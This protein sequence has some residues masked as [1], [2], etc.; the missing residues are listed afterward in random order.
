MRKH[1]STA[2]TEAEKK[3]A[4]ASFCSNPSWSKMARENEM[5]EFTRSF[6]GGRPDLSTLTHSIVRQRFL[7][8]TGRDHLDPEEKQALKQLV[9]EELL[10]MQVDEAGARDEGLD[11][12]R[13]A[14]RLPTHCK[15]PE[16]KRFRLN[17][18]SEPSAATSSPD[19]IS[20]PAKNG[21]AAIVSPKQASKSVESRDGEEQQRDL[22]A[23]TGL[24]K[25]VMK[26]SCKEE[27]ES[28]ARTN[29]VWKEESSEEEDGE[30]DSKGRARKKPGT[31]DRTQRKGD[32]RQ[33]GSSEE[34]GKDRWRKLRPATKRTRKSAKVPSGKT[35]NGEASDSETEVSDI[36]AEGIPKGK[37][38]NCS[39]RKSSK[40]SR[41][42][43][44]SSSSNGSPEFKGGRVRVGWKTTI[45]NKQAPGEISASRKQAMEENNSEEEPTQGTGN[46][47]AKSHQESEKESEEEETLAKKENRE[48]EEGWKARA[49]GNRGEKSA[50]EERSSKQKSRAAR[51]LGNGRER[52]E[53]KE[54][55]AADSGDNSGGDEELLMQRKSRGRTQGKG[56][57]RQSGSSEEDGEDRWR[58]LRPA[59][60]STG[61]SAKV[62]SGKTANG[63]ASD[64]EREVSDSEAGV[65]LKE[66]RKNRS[67][68]K[69]S[70]KCR[71]QSSSSSSNGSP[72]PKG[73]KGHHGE[74]HPAVMR[75]KRYIRACGAH[76]NYK[77]L[78]GSC[79]SH[80]E[81]LCILRAELEALGIKGNP[82]LEKC[83]ALK[84]Q[85]EEAAEVASL[86]ITNI[87]SCSGRPRRR[88]AWNPSEAAT[89]GELYR[90]ALDSEEERRR[91]PRPDWSH[92]RGIISSDGESN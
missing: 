77:K 20:P 92:M 15:E 17:S 21:M 70:K 5:Q 80:K 76:R 11:L 36:E 88:T 82:S 71:T 51:V 4:G 44:S 6:F 53:E 46:T 19:C 33:S 67:Y 72:E 1:L 2:L 45:K 87:I 61:K 18:E 28:S 29:K 75:L 10:K 63:E 30:K 78:L 24:E 68:K 35:A 59:S 12:A 52:E 81:R 73:R 66:E 39:Y 9:E 84:E 49:L 55:A 32:K 79:R 40:R 7:S 48:E 43:S 56:G 58:K 37:R 65:T 57:K 8:H 60:K 54:K 83:R 38:K 91:P 42:W 31:R 14:R 22:T 27:E 90:R 25:E 74:D 69:S 13:E 16:R 86:D 3:N 64:S 50:W 23:K 26:E 85:R 62:E 41:T 34:D 47:G 89:P